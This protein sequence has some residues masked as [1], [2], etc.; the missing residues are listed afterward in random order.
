M[1]S[2]TWIV[3]PKQCAFVLACLKTFGHL[4]LN[5]WMISLILNIILN[6]NYKVPC[7][8]AHRLIGS[9]LVAGV[10]SCLIRQSMRPLLPCNSMS[11]LAAG[12][13]GD[14]CEALIRSNMHR[15]FNYQQTLSLG[16]TLSGSTMHLHSPYYVGIRI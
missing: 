3:C 15:L 1:F 4:T 11:P 5:P 14:T 6:Y 2:Y 12:V 9:L 13:T 16:M 8:N 7:S 10:C